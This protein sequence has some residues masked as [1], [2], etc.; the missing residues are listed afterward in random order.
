MHEVPI[1]VINITYGMTEDGAESVE[2]KKCHSNL[3]K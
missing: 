1:N 3:A 2:V